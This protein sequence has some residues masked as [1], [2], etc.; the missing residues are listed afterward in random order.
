MKLFILISAL[1]SL[2]SLSLTAPS[3]ASSSKVI[4]APKI[5]S[6]W[7]HVGTTRGSTPFTFTLHLNG[8]NLAGLA[9]LLDQN[10]AIALS[11]SQVAAYAS[12]TNTTLATVQSYLKSQGIA[13]AA[14]TYN[15]F[16]D[17]ITVKSTVSQA[18]KLFSAN[19]AS[20][21]NPQGTVV[22]RTTSYT[23]PAQISS[24]VR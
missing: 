5:P 16:K 7:K 6:S 22:P 4:K 8:A 14:I 13:D 17:Q 19:L 15:N 24:A 2:V 11:Q 1:L 20:Y 12:P 9:S 23:I 18:S 21:S 10:G 3:S